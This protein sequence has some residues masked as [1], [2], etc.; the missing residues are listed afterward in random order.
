MRILACLLLL[1]AA[2]V[3]AQMYKCVDANGRARY[4]DKPITDC[5]SSEVKLKSNTYQG[6]PARAPSRARVTR[7]MA[8]ADHRC[9]QLRQ[10]HARLRRAP[11]SAERDGKLQEIRAPLAACS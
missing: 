11:D 9:N 6:E 4:S 2:P 3:H 10:E 7:E 5:K 8:E 1:A